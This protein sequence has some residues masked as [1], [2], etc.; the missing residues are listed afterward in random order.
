MLLEGKKGLVLNVTNKNSIGW[1]IADAA[2]QHG[3]TVGVGGQNERLMEGVHK[4]IDGRE[5]FDTFTIDFSQ[6]E[7]FDQ[8]TEQVAAK[9]GKIDFLVHSVGFAPKEALNGRFIDTNRDDFMLAMDISAYS[10]IRVAKALEPVMADD[11][12][13]IALSYLGSTRAVKNYN[14]MGVCKAALEASVRYLALDLGQRGIRV[15]TVSPGPVN[16]IS[17]RGVSGLT[18]MIKS[19][20]QRAPLQR[21]Y[22]QPEVGST[23][24]YLLSDLSVGVTGQIIF[25]DSGFNILGM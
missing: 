19:V 16:T 18:D 1:A 2:N 3:A 20:H 7:A 12:S 5:R 13:V 6:E 10:L 4:L 22:A 8:L 9:Y 23:A 14:V 25:V 11:G 17:G 24:V 15:N 21:P